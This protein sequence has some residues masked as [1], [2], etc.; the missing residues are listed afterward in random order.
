MNEGQNQATVQR[1]ATNGQGRGNQLIERGNREPFEVPRAGLLE[2]PVSYLRRLMGDVD[3]TLERLFVGVGLPAAL[4]P[5]YGQAPARRYWTPRVDVFEREGQLM[6]HVD[7]PGM[8]QE[9]VRVSVED[10]VLT[11]SGERSHQHEHE[12]GGVYQCE[13]S[14]GIFQRRISLPAGIP[15][16]GIHALFEDGV[17]EVSMPM[18]R[19]APSKGRS[20]PVQSKANGMNN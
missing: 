5:R 16:E 7:L 12:K 20:V 18:P 11:I 15:S 14:Y 4:T 3:Q 1:G 2:A 19:Q 10:N 13:R 8:R 17:L 9:D 6:V